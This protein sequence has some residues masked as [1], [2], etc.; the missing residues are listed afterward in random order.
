MMKKKQN[1]KRVIPW[2]SLHVGLLFS[3]WIL[4]I[5]CPSEFMHHQCAANHPAASKM[6]WNSRKP[7]KT[8]DRLLFFQH[9]SVAL[10]IRC[11]IREKW[12]IDVCHKRGLYHQLPRQLVRKIQSSK[13]RS[14]STDQN[15]IAFIGLRWPTFT[16]Q[17]F[18]WPI[19]FSFVHQHSHDTFSTT[20]LTEVTDVM[21]FQKC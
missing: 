7:S 8:G 13:R 5:N 14:S 12:G 11:Y 2:S 21:S 4:V 19:W 17:F 10:D 15:R 3:L 6:I 1:R 18:C 9:F 20:R 16:C